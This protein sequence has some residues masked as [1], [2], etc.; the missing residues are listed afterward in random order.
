MKKLFIILFL[1]VCFGVLVFADVDTRDG[2]AITDATN[3]DG[4]T[5]NLDDADGQVIKASAGGCHSG[6]EISDNFDN[7]SIDANWVAEGGGSW[8][9]SGGQ[10]YNNSAGTSGFLRWNGATLGATQYFCWKIDTIGNDLYDYQGVAFRW[11]DEGNR[12]MLFNDRNSNYIVWGEASDDAETGYSEED[13]TSGTITSGAGDTI[14]GTIQGTGASIK[15]SLWENPTNSYPC[16]VDNW[17]SASDAADWTSTGP[18]TQIDSGSYIGLYNYQETDVE[19]EIDNFSGGDLQAMRN[20]FLFIFL[21]L[22]SIVFA[23][24]A[25][26]DVTGTL[27]DGEDLTITGEGFGSK[28]NAKPLRWDD[29]ETCDSPPCNGDT[30]NSPTSKGT[31]TTDWYTV[32]SAIQYS[33]AQTRTN[34]TLSTYGQLNGDYNNSYGYTFSDR[35]GAVYLSYW[36]YQ[37]KSGS[38]GGNN[39]KLMRNYGTNGAGGDLEFSQTE[40]CSNDHFLSIFDDNGSQQCIEYYN[41]AWPTD[42]WHR[43]EH[44]YSTG[45]PGSSNGFWYLYRDGSLIVSCTN[46]SIL[47]GGSSDGLA[48]L[49]I[50]HYAGTGQ[51]INVY[52]DDNYMD[53]TP[54]RVEICAGS[55]WAAK[56]VCEIQLPHTTWTNTSITVEINQAAFTQLNNKYLYVVDSNN[57][58]NA[59]G[60]DLSSVG[61]GDVEMVGTW[62]IKGGDIQ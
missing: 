1:L 33:N 29:F 15:L 62:T 30:L 24:P 45:T 38:C 10:I 44:Y 8:S 14:C 19:D 48:E 47:S 59:S 60:Y 13:N 34:S 41:P 56:G 42:T 32:S 2:T 12:Y 7:A 20:L 52:T 31:D 27:T 50:G 3:L 51:T 23:A 58:A 43:M 61:T 26:T 22:P 5:S 25:V 17:D 39:Y 11:T 6:P 46:V 9:E 21:C 49:R 53:T 57:D 4:F 37:T 18:T 28:S 36:H 16:D 54:Q 55:T 35:Q 40:G